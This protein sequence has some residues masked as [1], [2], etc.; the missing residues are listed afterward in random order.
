MS[1]WPRSLQPSAASAWVR[2]HPVADAS[3]APVLRDQDRS[4]GR[5]RPMQRRANSKLLVG[6]VVDL[7]IRG[8][9][10]SPTRCLD[11]ARLARVGPAGRDHLAVGATKLKRNL[12]VEPFLSTSLAAI[13]PPLACH[14]RHGGLSR[15]IQP[16]SS[17]SRCPLGT[18]I[19]HY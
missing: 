16:S 4:A 5:A 10:A 9:C 18:V 3:G 7:C 12:P 1:K 8:R 2:F 14:I 6:L 15:Q 17:G 11:R 19:D 13:G